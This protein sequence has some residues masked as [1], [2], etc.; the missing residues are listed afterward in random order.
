MYIYIYID[1]HVDASMSP[2]QNKTNTPNIKNMHIYIY[3]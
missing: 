2:L 1:T 3:T